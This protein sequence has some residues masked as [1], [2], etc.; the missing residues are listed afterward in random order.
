[1]VLRIK[2]R[3]HNSGRHVTLSKAVDD[4]ASAMAFII[5]RTSL[6]GARN[7]HGEGY[8][9]LGDY[10][11]IGVINEFV[12]YCVQLTDR[13]AHGRMDDASRDALVTALA[14]RLADQMQDN[15]TDIAGPGNYRA[16]FIEALNGRLRSYST[17]SFDAATGPGFDGLR[18]FGARVLEILGETQ[19][20]RWVIDQIMQIDGPDLYDKLNGAFANL[21]GSADTQP[22]Q[23]EAG[24]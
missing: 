4:H 1:M 10:E 14:H 18:V 12:A 15:L 16:P 6:E 11:R 9:Y 13:L 17:T 21:L 3:W 23:T 20:N 8:E 24:S 7:L 5:W 2:S 22:V 19:T